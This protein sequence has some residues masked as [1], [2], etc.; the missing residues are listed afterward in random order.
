MANPLLIGGALGLGSSLLGGIFGSGD[1]AQSQELIAQSLRDYELMGIPPIEAQKLLLEEL[2]STGQLTPDL[3]QMVVQG[4][5][6]VG[7]I[8]LDPAYKAS[9]LKALDELSAI[10]DAGGM[11]LSDEASLEQALSK[12]RQSERGSREAIMANARE[13][14]VA[15]SGSELAAQLANQQNSAQNAYGSGLDIAAMAQ[16]RAL[17]AIMQG[18]ELGGKLRSQEYGEKLDAARA[19]DEIAKFNTQNQI[20]TQQRN[21][22]SQNAAKERNLSESQRIADSNVGTRNQQQQ[23]NTGL[24]QQQFDN[25]LAL[26]QSKANARGNQ[27]SNLQNSANSTQQMFGGIGQGLAQIG[28]Q[29]SYQD[30]LKKKKEE[31]V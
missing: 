15:G 17:N 1:K 29:L 12:V 5:S 19:A 24:Y 18:G 14:G 16:D 22:M 23:Y 31:G 7:G 6:A 2:K 28:T 26:N 25:Q 27:A 8:A 20:S 11:R 21:V 4:P 10:G 13:R 9:Q 3:E 30:L